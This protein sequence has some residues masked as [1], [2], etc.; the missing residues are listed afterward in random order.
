MTLDP[1]DTA[2]FETA[3]PRLMGIAYR[4][5]GSRADAEDAVQ[6]T[7]LR[8]LAADRAAIHTPLAWMTTAC[9]RRAIDMLR[10]A[11]RRRVDYPGDWLPEPVPTAAIDGPEAQAELQSSLSTGFLLLLERLSPRERAAY[12]LHDIFEMSY[13][14]VS[15]TLGVGQPACR[16]LVSRARA[17]LDGGDARQVIEVERQQ[18]LLAA[19]QSALH[20]GR[21]DALLPLLADDLRMT[22]DGGGKASSFAP[23]TGSEA[24]ALLGLALRDWWAGYAARSAPLNGDAGVIL[25][26]GAQVVAAI[27]VGRD[28]GGRVSRLFVMRNPEKLA[29]LIVG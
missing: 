18:A 3:R 27:T 12:L 14:D 2:L 6:D 25:T 17:R 23:V 16:Q 8:W 19:F 20:E 29:R 28:G 5:L 21:P 9:T 1:E 10:A 7:G 11:R 13:A 26:S 22:G 24:R 4:I 15:K